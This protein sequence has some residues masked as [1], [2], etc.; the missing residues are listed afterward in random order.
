MTDAEVDTALD[1][2][3]TDAYAAGRRDQ[4]EEDQ[5]E[6]TRLRAAL[7][8]PVQPASISSNPGEL[9]QEIFWRANIAKEHFEMG[10]PESCPPP[11]ESN[12]VESHQIKTTQPVQPQEPVGHLYTIAGIQHCTIE[13]V[14]PDG[15]LYTQPVQPADD[16]DALRADAARYRWL[17]DESHKSFHIVM[18][19]G[20]YV[21]GHDA[22]AS[23]DAAI[24]ETP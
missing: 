11:D 12:P 15:P 18:G 19:H 24:K 16:I 3:L 1:A 9:E 5:A 22:D 4:L 2:A 6:I 8:Q 23:I 21:D 20:K 7:A 17:R 14:L 10:F 13:T